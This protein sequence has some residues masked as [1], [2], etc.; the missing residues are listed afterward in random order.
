VIGSP[1]RVWGQRVTERR[2]AGEWRFTPTRVGTTVN[3]AQPDTVRPV[4]PHACGDNEIGEKITYEDGGSPPRVWGQRDGE[5]V[6]VGECRFTP[7]R[8]GTTGFSHGKTSAATVHPHA[9]GDN[10]RVRAATVTAFG[11]PPRV[12]GQRNRLQAL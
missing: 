11:S 3:A 5:P 2:W 7:T 8:V 12:W 6:R 1:P 10:L 9:C 4:H